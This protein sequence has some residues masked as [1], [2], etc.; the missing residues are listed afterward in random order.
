MTSRRNHPAWWA[1]LVHRISGVALALFLPA[2]F[3]VM[4]LA[5]HGEARLEGFLRWSEQPLVIAAEWVLVMLL[6]AHLAG[7]LRLMA[8]EFLAW[9]NWQKT[10]AALAGGF[11][12]ASGLIFVLAR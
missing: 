9:R 6:G 3:L 4:G 7:G 12:V 8:L 5:L 1:F 11:A 10:L 2:H